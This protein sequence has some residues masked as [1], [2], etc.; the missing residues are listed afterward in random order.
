MDHPITRRNLLRTGALFTAGLSLSRT[1]LGREV[2]NPVA[3][4][5][6]HEQTLINEFAQLGRE[7]PK[8]KARIAF[9]ENPHGISSKAKEA[10]LKAVETSNR[11]AMFEGQELKQLIAAREGVKPE[12]IMLSAGSSEL[13]T[14]MAVYFTGSAAKGAGGTILTSQ[15]TYDD[16]LGCAK[17][18]GAKIEAVPLTK[19][20]RYDLAAMKA[21]ITPDTKLVYICNPNNPTGTVVPAAELV[22]FCKEVSPKLPV[23]I[24]EAYIDFLKPEDRPALPKLVAE[25]HNVF[26][27]RTFS[28]IHGFAGLRLGY[29]IGP[30]KFLIELQNYSRGEWNPSVTTLK[31]GIA[32]YQDLEWQNFCRTENDK[33][34]E[35]LYKGLK[36]KGYEYVP[37]YANFVLFPIRMKTKTFE[38]E[39]FGNGILT[40]TREHNAQPYCRVSIGTVDEMGMFMDVFKKI[41]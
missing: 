15:F 19:E 2:W 13:L 16:F 3:A 9:N 26:L 35:L 10:I 27:T 30:E 7:M 36:E 4:N 32:S 40:S 39:M 5:A 8:L 34:R 22:A 11:Y 1:S 37:S 21:K 28:K 31:A 6:L 20:Y 38:K 17:K 23:F 24:D 29:A 18:F 14:A 41:A 12:N 25:G 33:A